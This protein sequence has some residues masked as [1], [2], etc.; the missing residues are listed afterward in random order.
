MSRGL[1]IAST[2]LLTGAL[3][4]L[5]ASLAAGA[6]APVLDS[7]TFAG[8]AP[9]PIGPGITSGS[10]TSIAGVPG[11]RLTLYVGSAGGGV[12]KSSDGGTSFKPIF[13]KYCAS[14]GAIAVDPRRPRVVWVG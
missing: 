9:R 12:W 13:D 11:E 14:I 4:L 2:T 6:E 5:T 10:I 3:A 8:L 1:R 7:E